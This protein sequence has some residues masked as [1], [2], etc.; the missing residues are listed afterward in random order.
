MRNLLYQGMTVSDVRLLSRKVHD[1]FRAVGWFC[2]NMRGVDRSDGAG[3]CG[4]EGCAGYW[5]SSGRSFMLVRTA[6]RREA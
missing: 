5:V 4:L 1:S 2:S 3:V 6:S